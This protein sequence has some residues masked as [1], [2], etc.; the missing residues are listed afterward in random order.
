MIN[1]ILALYE[2]TDLTPEQYSKTIKDLENAGQ[3]HPRGRL[4][5]FATVKNNRITISDIWESEETLQDFTKILFPILINNA[6]SPV[7]PEIQ[8][9]YNIISF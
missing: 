6:V 5:H 1:K 8:N 9:I 3:A 4:Y 7:N 2:F